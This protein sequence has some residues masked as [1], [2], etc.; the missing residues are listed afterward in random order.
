MEGK[1]DDDDEEEPTQKVVSSLGRLGMEQASKQ[2]GNAKQ[3]STQLLLN[4]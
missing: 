4:S 3:A 1:D 2:E